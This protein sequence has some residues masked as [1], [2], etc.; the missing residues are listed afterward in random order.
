M[1]SKADV[2][3]VGG[4]PCGSFSAYR[5]AKL[6]VDVLVCEEHSEI[7]FPSHCAGH[8]SL[9]GLKQ[10]GLR[11]PKKVVENE[12]RSV[13]FYSPSGN[14]FKV[15]FAAPV[16][17]VLDRMLFDRFLAGLA[18]EAGAVYRLCTK[19]DSFLFDSGRVSGVSTNHE[20]LKSKLVIDCEG[21]SSL[22]LKKV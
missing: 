1:G 16:T 5:M 7:G 21:C 15:K 12:I 3:I 4:G 8:V 20:A 19:V 9:Q 14:E 11:L 17:C 2:I 6:G 13:I 18:E 10:L 22:L